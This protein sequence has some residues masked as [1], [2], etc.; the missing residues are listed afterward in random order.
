MVFLT[1]NIA[2]PKYLFEL[3]PASS[4]SQSIGTRQNANYVPTFKYRLRL[5]WLLQIRQL[6]NPMKK[7][8]EIRKN[9]AKI[10]T[11]FFVALF[12]VISV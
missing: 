10:F 5:Q 9:E 1:L 3:N 6:L 11:I 8:S 12:G 2:L 7:T 4:T